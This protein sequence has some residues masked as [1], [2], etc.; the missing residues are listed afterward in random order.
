MRTKKLREKNASGSLKGQTALSPPRSRSSRRATVEASA[1]NPS[2]VD[3]RELGFRG[4]QDKIQYSTLQFSKLLGNHS[5]LHSHQ[6]C[7]E[8][9]VSNNPP[10]PPSKRKRRNLSLWLR[11]VL[12]VHS[13]SNTSEFQSVIPRTGPCSS[14][15]FGKEGKV[16]PPY[17]HWQPFGE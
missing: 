11:V 10:L 2:T 8:K 7:G 15:G 3:G 16:P 14:S 9:S 12:G 4:R 13:K 5:V 17:V 1:E 6:H